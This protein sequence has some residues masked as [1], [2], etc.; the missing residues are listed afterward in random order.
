MSENKKHWGSKALVLLGMWLWKQEEFGHALLCIHGPQWGLKI[1]SQLGITWEDVVHHDDGMCKH[2]LWVHK[3]EESFLRPINSNM[4]DLIE[5]AY[6]MLPIENYED[7]LYMNYKTGKP[8]TTSTLNRELQRFSE[9]FLE[10]VKAETGFELDY[11]PLKSNAFEIAW[12]LDMVKKYHNSKL[13]FS[14]LSSHMGHR[15]IKDTIKLL[16]VE[17]NDKIVFE[18]DNIKNIHEMKINLFDDPKNLKE[19][20]LYNF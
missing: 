13:V 8:L 12:A 11:K 14:E 15:T 18:Y 2:E 4:T 5:K 17:P 19:F 1:G 7:S 10:Y 3:K 20:I 6:A 9:K 16:E